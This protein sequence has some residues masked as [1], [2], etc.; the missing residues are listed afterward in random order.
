[1]I[2]K[3]SE[4]SEMK[5][6]TRYFFAISVAAGRRAPCFHYLTSIWPLKKSRRGPQHCLAIE[7]KAECRLHLAV[8]LTSLFKSAGASL[9]AGAAAVALVPAVRTAQ[10]KEGGRQ[11]R[12]RA[13]L[14][15]PSS[16]CILALPRIT[17]NLQKLRSLPI[18]FAICCCGRLA[19]NISITPIW[20]GCL[21]SALG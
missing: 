6:F 8:L 18:L 10:K 15:A 11:A 12:R 9:F 20:P 7:I 19:H 13:A 4:P 2:T 3:S 5:E 21:S 14:S 17:V 16:K 1:V